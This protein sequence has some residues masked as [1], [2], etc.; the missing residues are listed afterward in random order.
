MAPLIE[1][2][3]F[4]EFVA[5][6]IFAHATAGLAAAPIDMVAPAMKQTAEC[7]ATVMRGTP[8]ARDVRVRAIRD[9][10]GYFAFVEYAFRDK[11]G[12]RRLVHLNLRH[13]PKDGYYVY[14]Y[15]SDD[16]YGG[17]FIESVHDVLEM[18]CHAM[19]VLEIE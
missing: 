9:Q 15:P 11:L 12:N 2:M 1:K 19:A 18:K 13:E 17:P 3:L 6:L 7:M 14:P 16:V 5:L 8:G 4:G 10:G